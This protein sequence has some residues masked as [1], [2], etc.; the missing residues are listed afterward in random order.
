MATGIEKAMTIPLEQMND[1]E[2]TKLCAEAM[3]WKHLGAVGATLPPSVKYPSEAAAQSNGKLWCLSGGNDWWLDPN[4]HHICGVCSAIPDPLH[5]DAQA[6]ALVKRFNLAIRP[7]QFVPT[8]QWH[9][10]T[11]SS[12]T[13]SGKNSGIAID[14]NR[15]IVECVAKMH[16]AVQ[17]QSGPVAT[18]GGQVNTN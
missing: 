6:M 10:W 5:D 9:V 8:C 11:D 1:L 7:P 12:D 2:M 13:G 18:A 16:A 17:T 14:L 4:G 15:A 3:G